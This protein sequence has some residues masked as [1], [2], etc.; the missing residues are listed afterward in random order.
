V[1]SV[2][3]RRSSAQS[4]ILWRAAVWAVVGAGA[5]WPFITTKLEAARCW[6]RRSPVIR[7]ISNDLS[8]DRWITRW[9]TLP[10]SVQTAPIQAFCSLPKVCAVRKFLKSLATFSWECIGQHVV[11]VGPG[12]GS[13]TLAAKASIMRSRLSAT[14]DVLQ[15]ALEGRE[16]ARGYQLSSL[17]RGI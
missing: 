3:K 16:K 10:R 17:A 14:E 15:L 12:C 5:G 7:A 8:L 13:N 11:T 4:L 1:A 9:A 2:I 6:T